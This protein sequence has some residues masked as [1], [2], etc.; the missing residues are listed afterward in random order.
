M[1]EPQGSKIML[2]LHGLSVKEVKQLIEE[3]FSKLE[4]FNT[5][6]IYI[7][8]GRG[9]HVNANGTRGVLKKILPKLLKPYCQSIIQINE[10]TGAYKVILKP[11]QKLAQ[12]KDFLTSLFDNEEKQITIMQVLEK[13]V[14]QNDIEAMLALGSV[15]LHQ[16]FPGYEDINKGIDL[17]HQAKDLGSLEAYILL[18]A[19]YHDGLIAK[20]NH[21]LA[22][23]YFMHAA[24]KG[25]AIA[26]YHVAVCYL[27]GKGVKYNDPQAVA[28]MKKSADQGDPYAQDALSDFYLLGKITKQNKKEGIRY[29][30]KAANH[31]IPDAQIDLARCYATG[32]AGEQDYKKAFEWYLRA[33]KFDKPYALYQVGSYLLSGRGCP[34]PDPFQAMHWF[35]KAAELGDTDGQAQAA[36]LY[37]FG[38]KFGLKQDVSKALN[39]LTKAISKK[40]KFA[41]YVLAKAYMEGAGDI[42]KDLN[43]AHHFM[44][45]SA[46]AGYA[47]AQNELAQFSKSKEPSHAQTTIRNASFNLNPTQ[48]KEN[49]Q[50]AKNQTNNNLS[51]NQSFFKSLGKTITNQGENVEDKN[52]NHNDRNKTEEFGKQKLL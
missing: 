21:P 3:Q 44:K 34:S 19:L 35:I 29:K 18:G 14:E 11:Q 40:N 47:D 52:E 10:E 2:D 17:L 43:K 46:E 26:Q 36:N 42:K 45:L 48:E 9:N 32:Y 23:K 12:F 25:H 4:K 24:N 6:E 1:L 16:A 27:H 37:L 22:F 31:D 41:Y 39:Y 7:I 15:Y 13:K 30:I 33:A 20:Q 28:W 49:E 51:S 8:T 5:G 38:Q 50:L